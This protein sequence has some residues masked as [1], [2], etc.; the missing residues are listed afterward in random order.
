VIGYELRG[1]QLA[2]SAH[3]EEVTYGE[4]SADHSLRPIY[5]KHDRSL[6]AERQALLLL[7]EKVKKSGASLDSVQGK[8]TLYASHTPCTSCLA[9]CTQFKHLLPRVQLAVGFQ[10]WRD[11]WCEYEDGKKV[12]GPEEPWK[13]GW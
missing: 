6:H 11:A 5:C 9:A 13:S 12:A 1:P 7:I 8:V 2:A 4:W 10:D 3:V